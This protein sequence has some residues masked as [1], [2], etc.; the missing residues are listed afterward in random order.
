VF[1]AGIGESAPPLRANVCEKL[2]WLGVTLDAAANDNN[3]A[4]ITAAEGRVSVWVIPTNA[5]L[6]IA[7]HT[8][9]LAPPVSAWSSR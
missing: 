8:L 2:A 4:R 6:M 3:G 9:A 7:R 1:I 5:E